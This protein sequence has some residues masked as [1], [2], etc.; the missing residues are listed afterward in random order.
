MILHELT[1][2]C[3]LGDKSQFETRNLNNHWTDTSHDQVS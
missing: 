3:Y 2:F 1:K